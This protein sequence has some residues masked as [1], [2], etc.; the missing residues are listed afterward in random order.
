[1][2]NLHG[3]CAHEV[4]RIFILLLEAEF[5]SV[6]QNI[7]EYAGRHSYLLTHKVWWNSDMFYPVQLSSLSWLPRVYVPPLSLHI[8]NL[9][10]SQTFSFSS[11]SQS[12]DLLVKIFWHNVAYIQQV[13]P[14][15]FD[16]NPTTF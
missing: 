5:S 6:A 8:E 14:T 1:M 9:A 3:E 12:F 16:Q 11:H 4:M 15:K 10:K 7:L 13:Q 2:E